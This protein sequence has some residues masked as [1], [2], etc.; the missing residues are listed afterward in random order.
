MG[1]GEGAVSASAKPEVLL[2]HDL[3]H[4]SQDLS[5][6]HFWRLQFSPSYKRD[7]IFDQL[8]KVFKDVG[9]TSYTIYETLGDYDLLLRTWIPREVG[10]EDVESTFEGALRGLTLWK[11]DFF[12]C[13]TAVH[14]KEVE[15]KIAEWPELDDAAIGEVGEFNRRQFAR[16]VIPQTPAIEK[17]VAGGVVKVI[18]IDTRGIRFFI[19][20]DHPRFSFSPGT[21]RQALSTIKQTCDGVLADWESR[22]LDESACPQVSI[23]E[24]SGTMTDFLVL[25]RAPHTHFHEFVRDVVLGLR[26]S[27]L[28]NMFDIRPYTH[29]MADRMFS[30]FAEDRPESASERSGEINIGEDETESLEYKATFALNLRAVME[31][32]EQKFDK[33]IA[34]S[35]VRAVCGLLNSPQEGELVIGV[36]ETRRELERAKDKLT[37]LTRLSKRFGIEIDPRDLDDPPNAI[38]GIEAEIGEGRNFP[39]RDAYIRRL[40]DVIRENITPNPWPFLDMEVREEGGRGL[41]ILRVKPAG[42]WFYATAPDSDHVRFYVREAGSTRVYS[43]AESDLYKRANPRGNE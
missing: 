42:V 5:R 36:L 16:E 13:H 1:V 38:L 25:A 37:Y 23:Y 32:D 29:V 20:F 2:W 34:H 24:G 33:D 14:W 35:V 26:G 27:G 39:D 9:I 12:S 41:C 15:T 4:E 22:D 43:G 40:S 21:R 17:L 10:T 11:L 3:V 28:D 8:R 31:T 18:P 30:A 6:L 19:V 7:E